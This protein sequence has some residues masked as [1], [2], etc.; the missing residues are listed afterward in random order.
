[1]EL[2][3]VIQP[4]LSIFNN[5]RDLIFDVCRKESNSDASKVAILL[6]FIWQNRNN[7]VW[8][9]SK[10]SAQQL[11]IQAVQYW[12]QWATVNG[13][14]QQHQQPVEQHIAAGSSL[15]WQP[16]PSGYLKCNV[17]LVFTI[18]NELQDEVGV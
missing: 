16:P 5:P 18:R 14:L 12:Q 13:L 1:M 6:W 4:R 2:S 10:S 8:N 11:G 3:H 15:Q 17:M 9:N 7:L